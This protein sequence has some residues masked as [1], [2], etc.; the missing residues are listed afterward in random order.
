MSI[1]ND[2]VIISVTVIAKKQNKLYYSGPLFHLTF[3]P[4]RWSQLLSFFF[5]ITKFFDK[6]I[7]CQYFYYADIPS[8]NTQK[9]Y[10]KN[11]LYLKNESKIFIKS[12]IHI[13]YGR[14]KWF[15]R[16]RWCGNPS[17]NINLSSLQKNV[18]GTHLLFCVTCNASYL[19]H[20]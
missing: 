20:H 7:L 3:Y 4:P 18:T 13:P 8:L 9:G 10:Y 12:I 6:V 17:L 2:C 1:Q 5:C 15:D 16:I 11:N 19:Y 14:C